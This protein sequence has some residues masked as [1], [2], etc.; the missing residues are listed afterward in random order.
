MPAPPPP[1]TL[2]EAAMHWIKAHATLSAV[3]GG[4]GTTLVAYPGSTF[5]KWLLGLPAAWSDNRRTRR[6]LSHFA[7]TYYLVSEPAV[8]GITP[9]PRLTMLKVSN[10]WF[11]P[12]VEQLNVSPSRVMYHGTP[13]ATDHRMSVAMKGT[14]GTLK[15]LHLTEFKTV[16][17]HGARIAVGLMCGINENDDP[18]QRACLVMPE[19]FNAKIMDGLLKQLKTEVLTKQHRQA[20][21]D[22]AARLDEKPTDDLRGFKYPWGDVV[23]TAPA[24][25]R[26]NVFKRIMAP[27]KA[28]N[29]RP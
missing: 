28:P 10:G 18:F 19:P 16:G 23:S 7:G 27:W 24:P 29:K 3:A 5:G 11:W 12:K 6:L 26:P 15:L 22:A 1:P 2:V 17:K 9:E 20:V 21:L 25:R 8:L 13:T 4:F 14:D